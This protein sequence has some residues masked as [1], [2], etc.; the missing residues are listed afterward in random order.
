MPIECHCCNFTQ[1]YGQ[2]YVKSL[3]LGPG[4]SS[5]CESSDFLSSSACDAKQMQKSI[6]LMLSSL[7]Y[8]SKLGIGD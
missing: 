5:P 7:R 3:L 2:F 6:T 1:L 4:L 8:S